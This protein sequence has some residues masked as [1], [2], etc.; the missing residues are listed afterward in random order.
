V[1]AQFHLYSILQTRQSQ[2]AANQKAMTTPQSSLN[3]ERIRTDFP[4]LNREVKPG[5]PLI[6][7]DSAAS[8][9]KPQQVIE[10]MDHYYRHTHANIHR[11]VH[12]LAEEATAAYEESR[13]KVARFINAP[14]ARQ[15]IFTRNATESINL[16]AYAWGRT[17]IKDGD[18]IILTEMEHHANLV[19]W[20][21]L[22]QEKM[23]G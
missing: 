1:S 3:V 9:Q 18:L 4:I 21:V 7:L 16:V 8:S 11:G 5:V 6:Y 2:K 23:L 14:H 17:N 10:S 12:T 22:A 13:E 15:V 19:P 20:Q